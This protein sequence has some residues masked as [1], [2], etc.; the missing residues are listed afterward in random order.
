MK[1]SLAGVL[2]L[3]LLIGVAI[4]TAPTETGA[5]PPPLGVAMAPFYCIDC[6]DCGND[7]HSGGT[8][9]NGSRGHGSHP[10]F[11]WDEQSC[12]DAHPS[13]CDPAPIPAADFVE[14]FE[15][16]RLA[17]VSETPEMFRS[18]HRAFPSYISL[19]V[20]RRSIQVKSC[21]D[22]EDV[23]ANLPVTWSTSLVGTTQ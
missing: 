6:N 14:M 1:K 10:S 12:E 18:L 4:V 11:C 19:N 21:G 3:A 7:G 9:G 5:S 22:S 8:G 2:G 15:R 16:A 20:D 23:V 13:P 17:A